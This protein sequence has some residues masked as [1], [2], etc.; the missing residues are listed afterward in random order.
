MPPPFIMRLMEKKHEK[1]AFSDS[2]KQYMTQSYSKN[3]V[4]RMNNMLHDM[5]PNREPRRLRV[6]SSNLPLD[7]KSDMFR[8][9]VDNETPKYEEWVERAL[10][11]PLE[12]F[13]ERPCVSDS[14]FIRQARQCMDS[15]ITGHLEAKHEVLR[16]ICSWLNGGGKNG[17]AIG[18]EGRPGVGK[19]TFVRHALSESMQRPFCFICLGGASDAGGLLGHSYT[20]EGAVPGRLAECVSRC[21][22]MDPIIYFDEL[23]KISTSGKGDELVHALIHLTDP[24]QNDRIRDRYL[25]GIDLDLSRAVLVFSYNDAS[26]VNPILLDRIKRIQLSSPTIDERLEICTKH[27]VP[28]ILRQV[29]SADDLPMQVPR[30]VVDYIIAS[31]KDEGGMRSIE[32]KLN[33]VL[34]SYFLVRTYGS[35]E[36]LGLDPGTPLRLDVAF[37][38]SVLGSD[39]VWSTSHSHLAM[40]S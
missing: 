30:E 12:K 26:R 6:L 16:M 33:H 15:T 22:V 36:V 34:S 5:Q 40:Y 7:V 14:E 39:D 31:N 3:D 1:F 21:G 35:G 19:T 2:E 25:H 27:I 13:C 18:L 29:S 28:R 8:Q 9:L 24:V 20:Y 11:L 10:K 37:A 4:R 23:D 32:K 17:F 38:S